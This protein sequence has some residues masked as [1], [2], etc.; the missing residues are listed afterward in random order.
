[1]VNIPLFFSG[2]NHPFGGV[3]FLL[4]PLSISSGMCG[5]FLRAEESL[6]ASPLRMHSAPTV[7]F[8]LRILII[9]LLHIVAKLARILLVSKRE[10]VAQVYAKKN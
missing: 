9:L 10:F 1:M 4:H 8:F 7:V 5:N 6:Q 2:F 3:G